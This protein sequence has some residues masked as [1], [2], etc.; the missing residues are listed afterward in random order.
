M[1]LGGIGGQAYVMADVPGLIEGA[2][3]GS[4][5]G[6]AF[7]RHVVRTKMLVHVL[8]ASGGLEERDPLEDFETINTELREYDETLMDR[9]MLV[10]LNKVDLPEAQANLP[11]L[12]KHMKALKLPVFEI[13]A[14]T[15]E[16]VQPLLN[17]IGAELRAILERALLEPV[18]PEIKTIT[19]DKGDER[20]FNVQRTSP[21]SFLVTGVAI[22]RTTR[23]TNFDQ[24]DSADRFQRILESTGVTRELGRLGVET[25]DVVDIA[26]R[27][28]VW[29]DLDDLEPATTARRTA[30]ERYL[31]RKARIDED[32]EPAEDNVEL[33][34]E[35]ITVE[36][37]STAS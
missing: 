3:G 27:E 10:A 8:D 9:P 17:Q 28:L 18:E 21:T 36:E 4:G 30:R 19:L 31:N 20:A 6:H 11:R 33:D 35:A 23:M 14:A 2:A 22:E 32:Y 12:R 1:E 5:L 29:G 16:G 34:L 7:L 13:S 15:S 26:G 37:P 25:G 24:I